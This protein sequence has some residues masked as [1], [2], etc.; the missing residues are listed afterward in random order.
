MW[1]DARSGGLDQRQLGGPCA[2]SHRLPEAWRYDGS[3]QMRGDARS[4]GLYRHLRAVP[5]GAC[6]RPREAGPSGGLR[7]LPWD[8]LIVGTLRRVRP[9]RGHDR[10]RMA[11]PACQWT[12]SGPHAASCRRLRC[13]G[14]HRCGRYGTPA[15]R[16]RRTLA[17]PGQRS[18]IRSLRPAVGS[19]VGPEPPRRPN[20]PALEYYCRRGRR[21]YGR[22]RPCRGPSAFRFPQPRQP[23]SSIYHNSIRTSEEGR[24]TMIGSDP[25]RNMSGGVLLSHTV[26]RAVPSALKSLTSGFGMGPGVSPSLLPPKLYGDIT[27]LAHESEPYWRPYLGNRIVDA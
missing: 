23:T 12:E 26:P 14:S 5:Y 7:R 19:A 17:G 10:A 1:G 20:A 6:R 16:G 8:V 13:L 27:N 15:Q 22:R 11:G 24:S 25:L 2:G 21:S 18:L 9:A 4:G 3:H